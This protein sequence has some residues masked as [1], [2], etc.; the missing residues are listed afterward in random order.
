MKKNLLYL[1]LVAASGFA[2]AG[3][4]AETLS[5]QYTTAVSGVSGQIS[6]AKTAAGT[7]DLTGCGYVRGLPYMPTPP[8]TDGA[9]LAH[10]LGLADHWPSYVACADYA[11]DERLLVLFAQYDTGNVKYVNAGDT[12]II[13]RPDGAYKSGAYVRSCSG[14]S[15]FTLL[16]EGKAF[17]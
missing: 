7:C 1:V 14:K 11:G 13:F 17:Y 12:Y 9:K 5:A 6:A 4:T 10:M 15:I 8:S 3:T 16:G 2:N